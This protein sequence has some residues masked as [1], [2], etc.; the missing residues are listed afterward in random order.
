MLNTTI[1]NLGTDILAATIGPCGIVLLQRLDAKKDEG[2]EVLILIS[3]DSQATTAVFAGHASVVFFKT[4][5]AIRVL[6]E[7]IGKYG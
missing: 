7:L 2:S 3:A 5:E 6:W 4:T 1:F